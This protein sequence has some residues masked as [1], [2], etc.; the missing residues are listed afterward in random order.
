MT[1]TGLRVLLAAALCGTSVGGAQAP[2]AAGLQ[3]WPAGMDPRVVGAAVARHF[4]GS[5]HQ[6]TATL[7]YSEVV[8]WYGALEIG[9]L[10]GD[11]ALLDGLETRFQPMLGE[12]KARIP[13]RAHVDDS[14]F[15]ALPLELYMVTRK[16]EYLAMG[17][18]FADRQWAQPDAQGLSGET[19]FWIDDMYM[20]TLLQVQAFRATGDKK[21]LDRAALEMVAY[22]DKLQQ[23]NGLFFHAPDVPYFW[24]RGDGWM[25]AGMTEVLR[26]L[27]ADDPRRPRILKGYRTMMAALVKFQGKDGMWRQLIDREES[28]PESSGSG[29]F[30]FALVSGVKNGWLTGEEYVSAARRGWIALVG[31]VDQ[32]NDVVEVCEGTGKKDDLE[33]YLERKRRTGDFHGQAPLMWAAAALLR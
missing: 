5:P 7:H 3:N 29:M 9:R 21:Y 14:V 23:P 30:T 11:T 8:S 32:N 33:Y 16:P 28:W 26:S 20:L 25:A 18:G 22:L 6:Y 15:G 2:K 24:G 4:V 13:T 27:P 10:T 12:D 17:Q 31:Y 1:K 19:R